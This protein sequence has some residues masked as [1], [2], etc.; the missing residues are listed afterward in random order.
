VRTLDLGAENQG[1]FNIDFDGKDANGVQLPAGSYKV[2]INGTAN[3]GSSVS[4]FAEITGT[5]SS[6]SFANGN[7]SFLIGSQSVSPSDIQSIDQ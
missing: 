1:T 6:V 7:I 2:V 3:D 5:V 4:A